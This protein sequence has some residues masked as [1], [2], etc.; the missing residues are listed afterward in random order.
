MFLSEVNISPSVLT[1]HLP[2]MVVMTALAAYFFYDGEVKRWHGVLLG[3]LY[4][5]Y[6][7]IALVVFSGVPI[8]E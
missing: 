7:V 5:A 1:F 2:A 8:G 4:V 3:G 6:W